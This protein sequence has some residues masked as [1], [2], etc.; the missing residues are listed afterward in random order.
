MI[1]HVTRPIQRSQ[2][3]DCLRFYGL[4]GFEEFPV[5]EGLRGR[6][7]WL[8]QRGSGPEAADLHLQFADGPSPAAGHVAFVVQPYEQ[9]LANLREAGYEVESR[10]EHWGSP[11]AYVRDPA[12]NLLEVMAWAP[13]ERTE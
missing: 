1:Q 4:L 7:V 11:R 6:A 9:T 13:G 8:A 12:A 2:L 10:P 5:P 3:D